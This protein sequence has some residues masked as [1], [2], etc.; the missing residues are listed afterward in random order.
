MEQ[1]A[2][3][4]VAGRLKGELEKQMKKL[5]VTPEARAELKQKADSLKKEAETAGKKLL[6][7]LMKKKK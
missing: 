5:D 1:R 3:Q 2:K 6:E 7:N 4:Y